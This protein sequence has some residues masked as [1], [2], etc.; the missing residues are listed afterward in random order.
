MVWVGG[1]EYGT[2]ELH[3]HQHIFYSVPQESNL[4]PVIE[5]DNRALEQPQ[6]TMTSAHQTADLANSNIIKVSF[7]SSCILSKL[8]FFSV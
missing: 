8:F 3:T 2:V 1:I 5:I 7:N 6:H 4:T